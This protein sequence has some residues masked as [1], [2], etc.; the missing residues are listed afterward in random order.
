MTI[1][2]RHTMQETRQLIAAKD[3]LIKQIDDAFKSSRWAGNDAKKWQ[4][5]WYA[6]NQ[7]WIHMKK[8]VNSGFMKL[9]I[10]SPGIPASAVPSED[11]WQMVLHAC[12]VSGDGIYTTGDLPDM[13]NRLEAV[14]GP[15]IDSSKIPKQDGWDGDLAGYKEADKATTGIK[16]AATSDTT[17]NIGLLVAAGVGIYI[18]GKVT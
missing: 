11:E 4:A 13:Q 18:V 15:F 10:M 7:R 9:S 3:A 14:I 5:D 6:F 8:E 17:R 2:G 1:A 12:N 16:T